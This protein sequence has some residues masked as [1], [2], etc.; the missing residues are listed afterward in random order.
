MLCEFCG[1]NDKNCGY[2]RSKNM[3]FQ[4]SYPSC[5]DAGDPFAEAINVSF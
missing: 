1:R 3:I 5:A 2:F 4:L